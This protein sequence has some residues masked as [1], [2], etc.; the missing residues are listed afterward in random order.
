MTRL[1]SVAPSET[2]TLFSSHVASGLRANAAAK[3]LQS[4][5]D[6]TGSSVGSRDSVAL[7]GRLAVRI[8]QDGGNRKTTQTAAA[9]A[10][11]AS[12]GR[13]VLTRR[14]PC[15]RHAGRAARPATR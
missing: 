8:I 15:A 3:A 11:K 13:C 14:I 7:V 4:S 9:I 12:R 1:I 10:V 2:R 6:Q 5:A